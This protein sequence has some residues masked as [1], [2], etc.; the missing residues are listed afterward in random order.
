[1]EKLMIMHLAKSLEEARKNKQ[2]IPQWSLTIKDFSSE[3]AYKV[4]WEGI[5]LRLNAGEEIVALKMGLTS[6]AKRK[7]M[8]LHS[9]LYG[10]LTNQ[11]KISN[12]GIFHQ[13]L[14]IHSKIEPEI[15]FLIKEDITTPI[16]LEDVP[17]YVEAYAPALEILDSR[18]EEFKYFSFQDVVADNSSSSHFVI[19][20]WKKDLEPTTLKNLKLIMSTDKGASELGT[21]EAINGDPLLSLVQLSELMSQRDYPIKKGMIVLAGA[22]TAALPLAE[23]MK[24]TLELES[25]APM[26]VHIE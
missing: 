8:N 23:K 17:Q 26:M 14:T 25:F 18:Y 2:G 10:V 3:D 15:A 12:G 16:T 9:P 4:L 7:Q 13:S 19:G 1:M 22:A 6:E 5:E 24:V 11:M 21:L 20:E